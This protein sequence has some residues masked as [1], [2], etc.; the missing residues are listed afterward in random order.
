M[1]K[2]IKNGDIILDGTLTRNEKEKQAFIKLGFIE[3]IMEKHS[4]KDLEELQTAFV[5][6]NTFKSLTAK[7][8]NKWRNYF[9]YHYLLF[10]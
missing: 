4:I 3:E 1:N 2:L 5:V 10:H 7:E 8:I 6:Y 9:Y